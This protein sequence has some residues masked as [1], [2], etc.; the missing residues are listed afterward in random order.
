[1]MTGPVSPV[2]TVPRHGE[3][4]M[5]TGPVSIARPPSE[6]AHDLSL[7][8][9]RMFDPRQCEMILELIRLGQWPLE[10]LCPR[11]YATPR[12]N[13]STFD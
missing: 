5:I 4:M 7:R 8:S 2:F 10:L 13:H 9:R 3:G 1:M 12:I 11:T 6:T